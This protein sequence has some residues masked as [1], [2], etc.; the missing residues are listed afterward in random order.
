[1]DICYIQYDTGGADDLSDLSVLFLGTGGGPWARLNRYMVS[2]LV[3][4]DG[5]PLLFDCGAGA[6]YQMRRAGIEPNS[7]RHLFLS[8]HHSDHLMDLA[9]FPLTAWIMGTSAP[10]RIFGPQGTERI[11]DLLFGREGVY[12]DDLRARTEGQ[13]ARTVNA[14]RLGKPLEWPEIVARDLVGN[15]LCFDTPT[16]RVTAARVPHAQ[17]HLESLAYRIDSRSGS[18]VITGDVTPSDEVVA[19][20]SGADLLV[21]ECSL[22]DDTLAEYGT[23]SYHSGP[24]GAARIAQKAGVGHLAL[25]HFVTEIDSPELLSEAVAQA[26][27]VFSGVVTAA[28]DLD[29]INVA[30]IAAASRSA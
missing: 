13:G 19:L 30:E 5:E 1:M 29:V 16:W 21:H 24:R 2:Q 14:R 12:R 20:A 25:T 9:Q 27:Q 22:F 28:H 17:P 6:T 11:V 23:D 4:V 15:G 8:H 26:R 7:V 10:L 3:V 18:V